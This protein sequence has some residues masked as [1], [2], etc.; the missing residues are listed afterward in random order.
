MESTQE[1]IDK[2]HER[3]EKKTNALLENKDNLLSKITEAQ[4]N[5]ETYKKSSF[6]TQI[7]D[8]NSVLDKD[9]KKKKAPTE[10]KFEDL[11]AQIKKKIVGIKNTDTQKE[12]LQ[13]LYVSW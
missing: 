9:K 2:T 3:L 1:N 12:P 13:L 11:L 7:Q 8:Q 6:G 10:I 4:S 5:L